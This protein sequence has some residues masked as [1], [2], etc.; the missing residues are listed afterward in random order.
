MLMQM[1][2]DSTTKTQYQEE[3]EEAIANANSWE[4]T[5]GTLARDGRLSQSRRQQIQQMVDQLAP[6]HQQLITTAQQAM[7]GQK[8]QGGQDRGAGGQEAEPGGNSRGAVP[9]PGQRQPPPLGQRPGQD[10]QAQ[11][12]QQPPPPRGQQQPPA[13]EQRSGQR[14][15]PGAGG[16]QGGD[17]MELEHRF[18]RDLDQ[19]ILTYNQ[20]VAASTQYL[21][22]LELGLLVVTLG[23]LAMEGLVVFRPAVNKI[24]ETMRALAESLQKT[25]AMA[26]RLEQE[27]KKSEKLLLN[28]LPRPVAHRLK[29]SQQAIADGFAEV[30]VLFADIVGF[31]QLSTTMPPQ[32]LVGLLNEIFS[33][34]DELAERHGLEKI[35]TIGDA[36]MVVGGLPTPRADHAEA[37]VAMA[38]DMQKAIATFNQKN[39]Q[40]VQIRIGINS[41]PVVAGV[42]GIK[43]FIYDLWGDTVN[44][45]SRMEAYGVPGGIHITDS[46]YQRIKHKYQ[47]ESQGIMPIKGKGDMETYLIVGPNSDVKIPTTS[48]RR[49][50]RP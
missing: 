28:I 40:S 32:Q 39:K 41:G 3:M 31:T 42:I 36:Y 6:T 29:E 34:F 4:Q 30:S 27:Q 19:L 15:P 44:T 2:S 25:Q 26:K 46:T 45:A 43:K 49:V 38:I 13:P 23:V 24:R 33:T 35:K 12:G 37:I 5:M 20:Q 16:Q 11:A 7:T 9:L 8:G 48:A 47:A 14:Q 18:M 22:Q 1:S 10:P 17:P 21:K 50:Q